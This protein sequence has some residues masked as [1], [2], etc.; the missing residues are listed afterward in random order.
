MLEG[1]YVYYILLSAIALC[2]SILLPRPIFPQTLT[3]KNIKGKRKAILTSRN[4]NINRYNPIT[5]PR[6][7]ITIMIIPASIG[8]AAHGNDPSRIRHLIVHLSQRGRHLIG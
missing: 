5:P 6:D 3:E 2:P 8:A 4:I 7:R 1:L